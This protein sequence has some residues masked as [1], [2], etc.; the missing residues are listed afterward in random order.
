MELVISFS[1]G[2]DST[3]MLA[4][5][6][7]NYPEANKHVVFADT[8]WEHADA[9]EWCRSIVTGR[10]GLPLHVVRNPN[11]DFFGMVRHR[12]MFPGPKYRQCTSDLK[13]G[14]IQ[15]WIRNNITGDRPIII[16][17]MGIRAAESPNR[18][19]MPAAKPNKTMTNSKR[20]VFD[21]L[22]IHDWTDE[23]VYSYLEEKGLPLHPAYEYLSRFSCRVCIFMTAK[24]LARAQRHDPEAIRIIADLEKEIDFTMF[25]G[26]TIEKR[27]NIL[28][29]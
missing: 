27:A 6:V 5:L 3:A 8:G 26:E 29:R 17:A 4:Y 9:E 15:K 14:P 13:R 16:N 19:R 7:E 11:K 1:G 12:Q 21:W 20:K 2:K 18:K 25:Q 10:F 22:P 28:K 23:Q 24:D